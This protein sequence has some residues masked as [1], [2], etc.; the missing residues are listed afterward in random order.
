MDF[1]Q[2]TPLSSANEV[3]SVS[4]MKIP[5]SSFLDI[6]VS[7]AIKVT[8]KLNYCIHH[9]PPPQDIRPWI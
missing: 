7:I 9:L 2:K 6:L 4:I 5:L 8:D 3:D 1:E